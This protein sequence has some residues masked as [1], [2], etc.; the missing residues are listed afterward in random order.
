VSDL[1][2]IAG[3]SS[4]LEVAPKAPANSAKLCIMYRPAKVRMSVQEALK[5]Q[6]HVSRA[7]DAAR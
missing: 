3:F 7:P 2:Q 5:L 6:S 1:F 4:F